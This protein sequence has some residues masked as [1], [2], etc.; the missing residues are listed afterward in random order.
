MWV[1]T[2]GTI[3]HCA[4]VFQYL[5]QVCFLVEIEMCEIVHDIADICP[6]IFCIKDLGGITVK[7][8]FAK[9]FIFC[10]NK[11]HVFHGIK[12]C[13]GQ[14]DRWAKWDGTIEPFHFSCWVT[15]F[16][17]CLQ[18]KI[19]TQDDVM[20]DGV[21][22]KDKTFLF[23]NTPVFYQTQAASDL[24]GLQLLVSG[25]FQKECDIPHRTDCFCYNFWRQSG[26]F[27]QWNH[28]ARVKQDS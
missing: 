3:E 14:T 8:I 12:V 5:Q 27:Y 13:G 24:W 6:F 9:D 21:I 19:C 7:L 4:I 2:K 10:L 11:E 16:D 1:S 25:S 15:E 17:A 28:G 26:L 23:T 20:F 18:Q 22:V